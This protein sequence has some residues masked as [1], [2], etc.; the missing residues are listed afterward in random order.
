[1]S[2]GDGN[3]RPHPKRRPQVEMVY[4]TGNFIAGKKRSRKKGFVP[5]KPEIVT[6]V[7]GDKTAKRF[8]GCRTDHELRTHLRRL[9]DEG[10]LIHD[11]PN[12]LRIRVR[13][14]EPGRYGYRTQRGIVVRGLKETIPMY[15]RPRDPSK[16]RLI[17]SRR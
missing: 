10:R 7:L 13:L 16:G 15:D 9:R 6:V 17:V 14:N 8:F 4:E 3:V 11:K 2:G 5:P 12:T 1:M